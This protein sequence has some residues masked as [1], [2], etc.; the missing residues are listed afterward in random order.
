MVNGTPPT[1]GLVGSTSVDEGTAFSVVPTAAW[2]TSAPDNVITSCAI[3]WGDGSTDL[4]ATAGTAI[5]HTYASWGTY[6][7]SAVATDAYGD[8]VSTADS[9]NNLALV[10]NNLPPTANAGGPYNATE[11]STIVLGGSGIDPGND[12]AT[13]RWDLDNDGIFETSGATVD[14]TAPAGYSSFPVTFQVTDAG[15][16]SATSTAYVSITN[17]SPT[18]AIQGAQ[19]HSPTGGEIDL[20]AGVSDPGINDG[21]T[22]TYAW[23]ITKDGVSWD[24]GTDLTSAN[25][26]LTPTTA[27]VY[28]ATLLVTDKDGGTGS[29][30]TTTNVSADLMLSVT[31]PTVVEGA[32]ATFTVGISQQ[33][34]SSPIYV[35]FTT[36]AG[37]A[38]SSDFDSTTQTLEFDPGGALTQTVTV[39]T[40]LDAANQSG[41]QFS[42]A[43]GSADPSVI[44]G[45]TGTCTIQPISAALVMHEPDGSVVPPDQAQGVGDV[46]TFDANGVGE[47][48]PLDVK[49]LTPAAVDGVFALDYDSSTIGIYF[50]SSCTQPVLSGLTPITP[51]ADT[52]LYARA[53]SPAHATIDLDY[54]KGVVS[55]PGGAITGALESLYNT[56]VVALTN[57]KLEIDLTREFDSKPDDSH[58]YTLPASDTTSTVNVGQWLELDAVLTPARASLYP[59]WTIP[60]TDAAPPYAVG[61][62]GQ[63][64]NA[65]AFWPVNW[66]EINSPHVQFYWISGGTGWQVTY[67]VFVPGRAL[68]LTA[69]ATFDVDRPTATFSSETTKDRPAVGIG[70][71]MIRPGNTLH[72]GTWDSPGITWTGTV[73]APPDGDG[74]VQLVQLADPY[75]VQVLTTEGTWLKSRTETTSL[76]PGG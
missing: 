1:L 71:N 66:G 34:A 35:S 61:G 67:S 38:G 42:V 24:P 12:I 74:Q 9:N 7:V 11:G 21:D 45:A 46:L 8:T 31:S 52:T 40:H 17:V 39:P 65:A 19:E 58:T 3:D 36:Q 60:G 73:T 41:L 76:T 20:A 68:P 25:L 54:L 4:D 6:T 27:G 30:S 22:F 56:A 37:T 55:G 69:M 29:A 50:D 72:F 48:A 64:V 15:G 44:Y 10:V 59:Q 16:L 13:Y 70:P 62:Y 51:T 23:S 14:F 33:P 43:A 26:S 63:T 32:T 75:F 49:L 18:V 47:I 5:T 2:A 57:F 28:A 53:I